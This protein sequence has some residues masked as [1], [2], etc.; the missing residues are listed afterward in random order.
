MEGDPAIGIH[1]TMI[2]W[3]VLI[4]YLVFTTV[5]G[6][7]LAGKQATIRDFF[8][9]GRKLPWLAVTG[10]IIATEVSAVTFLGV[11]AI[12]FAAGGNF[13][14]LQL[15]IGAILARIIIGVWFVPAFYE[16]EIYSPYHYVGN[17]LGR[18]VESVTSGLFMLGGILAQS[19]RVLLTAIVLQ[20]ITD[21]PL[22]ASIWI[23]GLV[24]VIWTWLGGMT[25]V[26]WTDVI[27]FFVFVIGLVVALVFVLVELPGGWA[28]MTAVGSAAGK[29]RLWDLST[30]PQRMYT[31]WTALFANTIVCLGAYGTDQLIAQRMFCC[32]GPREARAAIIASSA[33]HVLTVLALLVGAALYAYYQRFPMSAE[34]LE[35]V[36]GDSDKV[37]PIFII[38]RIPVGLTGLL[39]AGVF[40]AAISSLDSILAALSQ[41]VVTSFYKPWRERRGRAG[42]SPDTPTPSDRHYVLVSRVLVVCWAAVLCV[43]AILVEQ[44]REHYEGI[45]NLALAMATYTAGALLGAFCLA[46][47][48]LNVDYRGIV[49]SAPLSVL[50]VFAIS[51]HERWALISTVVLASAIVLGWIVHVLAGRGGQPARIRQDVL[52]TLLLILGATLCVFL[53]A[54]RHPPTGQPIMVAW[55]WNVPVGFSVAFGLGYLLAR[56]RQTLREEH[57]AR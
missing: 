26:I 41:T 30:D 55:P 37:F 4:G 6:G 53:C 52:A 36:G 20:Q 24:A 1:F 10:S 7:L 31:L 51:W 16:R 56:P 29:F 39:I 2:D 44:A 17:Q 38:E 50:A 13:T 54:Y 15:A 49:W 33:S 42:A 32:R 22:S 46:F 12:V 9:G 3:C 28:E 11:P 5:L 21:I 48:K 47:F 23:I 57:T 14:Y 18:S 27:Q 34:A 19:T 43:M 40:A 45:L 35:R 8:L 25:T